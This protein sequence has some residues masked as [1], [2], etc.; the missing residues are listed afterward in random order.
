MRANRNATE[1]TG[2]T[3]M[4]DD[5]GPADTEVGRYTRGESA[6]AAREVGRSNGQTAW[7][8]STGLMASARRAGMSPA[9][10]P[11]TTRIRSA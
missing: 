3:A 10:V 2:P 11:E 7:S 9:S 5:S 4:A 8:A 6:S 1:A